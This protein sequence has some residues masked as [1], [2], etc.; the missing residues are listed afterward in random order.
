MMTKNLFVSLLLVNAIVNRAAFTQE[1]NESVEPSAPIEV[2][3]PASEVPPSKPELSEEPQ[4]LPVEEAPTPKTEAI[5]NETLDAMT[6]NTEALPEGKSEEKFDLQKQ[7]GVVPEE[8]LLK[9]KNKKAAKIRSVKPTESELYIQQA[10]QYKVKDNF[11]NLQLNDVVEQ[12]LRKNYDQNLREKKQEQ[13]KITFDGVKSAFW[14][15]E[16]KINLT[17]NSQ[18]I[19]TLRTGSRAPTTA[20]TPYANGTLGLSLG[21]YTVFNWGKDYALYLNKKSLF[22]RNT[23]IFDESKREL[24]LDLINTFFT[25]AATKNIEKIR[26]DQLRQTSFLYR[27]N[28]EKITIGKTSKQDYYQARSEYLRSQNL[29]HT[30]KIQA[31]QTDENVA[32]YI[33]DPIGTKYVIL[34]GLDYKRIKISLDDA[35]SALEQNNPTLLTSKMLMENAEREYDVAFKENLPLPKFTINL[36]AYNKR[37]GGATN[38]T[39]YETYSNSGRIEMVASINTTWSLTGADGLFNSNK[40][41]LSRINRE[42]TQKEFEKNNHSTQSNLRLT[43]KTIISLQNQIAILEARLPSLQKTFDTVLENYLAN[44]SKFYDFTMALDDLTGTK[45]FYEETKLEHLKQKLTL[46]RLMGVEDFPGENFD[47]LATRLKGK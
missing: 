42:I 46:A 11:K 23:Q 24:K 45:I 7:T 41:A 18:R 31:D 30:A 4:T 39:V 21:D 33:A 27:L 6:E 14:M 25:L 2:L 28:K 5:P 43:Y 35:L 9:T 8:E 3:E 17:T 12:G 1:I 15:P 22:E 47:R 26:Q 13:N 38:S 40:M 34:E 29:Y 36:G 19:S 37:F 20:S 32:Y 10:D 16:L 44:R